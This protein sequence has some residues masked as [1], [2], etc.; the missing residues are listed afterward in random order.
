MKY[1]QDW[2]GR[3]LGIVALQVLRWLGRK[4]GAFYQET[5]MPRRRRNPARARAGRAFSASTPVPCT[6]HSTQRLKRGM[7]W[8]QVAGELPGFTESMLT[9]LANG[10][11]IGFPRVMMITQWLGRPACESLLELWAERRSESQVWLASISLV[12][13]RGSRESWRTPQSG[14]RECPARSLAA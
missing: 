1:T 14:P 12:P 5:A 2:M 4:P 3:Q 6:R 9:N 7:K 8:K 13:A 10:P 11:L